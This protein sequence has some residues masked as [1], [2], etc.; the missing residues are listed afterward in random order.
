M[1]DRTGIF[2]CL[3]C[4]LVFTCEPMPQGGWFIEC[5]NDC[6]D[7]IKYDN[8]LVCYEPVKYFKW[9]NSMNSKRKKMKRKKIARIG[10]NQKERVWKRDGHK[11]TY[12]TTSLVKSGFTEDPTVPYLTVDHVVPRNKGGNNHMSNLTTSCQPC[13]ANKGSLL[14]TEFIRA[15]EIK[16]TPAIA[17]FL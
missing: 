9:L 5:P 13:N 14:L 7:E 4:E 15:F 16:L 11:C 6:V 8:E 2:R 1:S 10:K 17:R 12:C 3:K